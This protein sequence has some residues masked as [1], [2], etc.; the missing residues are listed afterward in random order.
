MKSNKK[1]S[2]LKEIEIWF[3]GGLGSGKWWLHLT[4]VRVFS[5]L[6]DWEQVYD[7]DIICYS[8]IIAK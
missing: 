1:A 2:N 6:E 7:L 3:G 5:N 4:N 8:I